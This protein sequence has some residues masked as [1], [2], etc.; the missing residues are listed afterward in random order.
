MFLFELAPDDVSLHWSAVSCDLI[1]CLTVV[2]GREELCAYLDPAVQVWGSDLN[3]AGRL[4]K[5]CCLCCVWESHPVTPTADTLN[6]AIPLWITPGGSLLSV[7]SKLGVD[8]RTSQSLCGPYNPISLGLEVMRSD[9]CACSLQYA[10][11]PWQATKTVSILNTWK[12]DHLFNGIEAWKS[13]EISFFH[14][15]TL[16]VRSTG[17]SSCAQCC[18]ALGRSLHCTAMLPPTRKTNPA[19]K[20]CALLPRDAH[21]RTD[22]LP[23]MF[24]WLL[25]SH[26][27]S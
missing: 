2:I 3:Q 20:W 4:P 22:M 15:F 25:L 9:L 16:Q 26:W 13:R 23:A 18:T 8:L 6:Y 7:I 10:H 11:L 21:N 24:R 1:K 5:L 17:D 14:Y 12:H 27:T 19:L